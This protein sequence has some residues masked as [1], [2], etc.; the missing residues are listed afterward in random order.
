MTRAAISVL[1]I[2]LLMTGCS[3]G[4][5][6]ISPTTTPTSSATTPATPGGAVSASP[7]A[8]SVPTGQPAAGVAFRADT[9]LDTADA[10]GARLGVV[11]A[12]AAL[13]SGYDRVVLELGGSREGVPGW[14]VDYVRAP[15]SDGS[16]EPVKVAGKAFLRVVLTHV[17]YP[18]DT[19]VREPS[20]NRLTAP[21]LRLV[22][23]VVL[24]GVYEGQYTAF[25]GMTERK[26]FRVFR[27][28][29]PPRVVI[30]LRHA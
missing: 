21:G 27:L 18:D 30:D 29:A 2:G 10:N 22:R 8:T 17:G 9:R 23:E 6:V 19:G 15:V 26:P 4:N 1:L 12:R 20:P 7:L 11:G 13:Q 28:A 14:R 3:S 24:D 5:P 16:G 25:I